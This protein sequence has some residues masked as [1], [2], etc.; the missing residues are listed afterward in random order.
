M[1]IA[2]DETTHE[3]MCRMAP[4]ILTMAEVS[5][6]TRK[7]IET[8][9][10]YRK[11]SIGPKSFRLGRTVVYDEADVLAWIDEQRAASEPQ[12]VA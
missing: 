5:G 9:R 12:G 2:V 11:N 3:G 4:K 10:F 1:L 8:L 7:S 6:M